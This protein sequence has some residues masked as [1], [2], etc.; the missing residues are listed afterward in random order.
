MR[1]AEKDALY[2]RY[3]RSRH[4]EWN[5]CRGDDYDDA[6]VL[7]IMQSQMMENNGNTRELEF[8]DGNQLVGFS[9]VDY[10][11]H[12][13]SAVYTA[14][15]PAYGR[16]APGV[17]AVLAMIDYARANGFRWLYLGFLIEDHPKMG[18]KARYAP[19]EYLDE[20][21]V[22]RIYHGTNA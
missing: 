13:L 12:A 18:Y 21:T 22:W 7:G 15:D 19:G 16:R 2:L 20:T 17:F 11:R 14:F 6:G 9:T 4:D 10:G 1:T 5:C 3:Y 8:R